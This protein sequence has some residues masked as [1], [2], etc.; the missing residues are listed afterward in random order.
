MNDGIMGKIDVSL[1]TKTSRNPK[2]ERAKKNQDKYL[3]V[4]C[5]KEKAG[6]HMEDYLCVGIFIVSMIMQN[7]TLR[8]HKSCVVSFVIKNL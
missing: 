7:L 5:L 1:Q 8:I 4:A 3:K 2:N 6:N